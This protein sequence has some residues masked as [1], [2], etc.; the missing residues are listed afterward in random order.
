MLRRWGKIRC[1][2]SS[3]TSNYHSEKIA[4]VAFQALALHQSE[5][6]SYFIANQSLSFGWFGTNKRFELAAKINL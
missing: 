3:K 5:W 1:K 4:K 6:K 2:M